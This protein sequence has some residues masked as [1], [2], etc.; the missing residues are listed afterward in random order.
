MGPVLYGTG[1]YRTTI[2]TNLSG[3]TITF[4][5]C[6]P[7]INGFTFE[8]PSASFSN[9]SRDVPNGANILPRTL[10]FTCNTTSAA[11]SFASSSFQTGHGCR[12][13]GPVLPRCSHNSSATYGANG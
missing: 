9:A 1:P 5:T 13:T 3:T 8:S 11:S 7:S 10:P 2:F 12:N 4:T 6:F